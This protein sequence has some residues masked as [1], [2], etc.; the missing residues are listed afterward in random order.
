M[1]PVN[2]PTLAPPGAGLPAIELFVA[3]RIFALKRLLGNRP[4]FTNTF[5][6]QRAA[7]AA[8]VG[9]CSKEKGASRVLIRRLPGLEDSSRHWSVWMTL[10]HLRIVHLEMSRV[11]EALAKG[12]NLSGQASTAAVKPSPE[13]TSSIHQTYEDSCDH[14]LKT[15]ESVSDLKTKN[16]YAHPWF[17]PLNAEGWFALAG[18]H[19]AIH[20]AQIEKILAG[21]V[22]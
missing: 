13:A 7:V 1:N 6:Q 15:V 16:T 12:E 8:I 20:R 18:T 11:I 14:L 5:H 4:S 22:D 21:L 17:G 3:R 10:D 2:S 9:S 19:L